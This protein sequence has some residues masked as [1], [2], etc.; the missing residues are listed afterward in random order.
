MT[1]QIVVTFD[2]LPERLEPTLAAFQ[3]LAAHTRREEGALRFDVFRSQAEE[4]T[5]VLVED[6]ADQHAIDLH[7]KEEYTAA[8]LAKVDGAFR[9]AARV[10]R[11][12]EIGG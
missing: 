5:V 12:V 10:H 2:V 7:M 6:W 9:A 4:H 11:L 3:E 1:I 8:F